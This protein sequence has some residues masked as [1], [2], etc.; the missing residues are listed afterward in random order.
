MIDG[1]SVL[2]LG[3]FARLSRSPIGGD[4]SSSCLGPQRHVLDVRVRVFLEPKLCKYEPS[5][6]AVALDAP[7][8]VVDANAE[9]D[10]KV[11]TYA[12]SESGIQ[13]SIL[14]TAWSHPTG[15]TPLDGGVS[16]LQAA[17]G[18]S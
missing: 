9:R 2:T 8:L 5:H 7:E 14:S 12:M 15:Q 13:L 4:A 3:Q 17:T 18:K 16:P 1:C 10:S 6:L 11:R